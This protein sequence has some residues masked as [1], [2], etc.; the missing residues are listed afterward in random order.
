MSADLPHQFPDLLRDQRLMG[1]LKPQP[2][3]LRALD[4]LFVLVGRRGVAQAD[5]VSQVDLVLQHLGDGGVA[6]VVG[7]CG[8]QAG[9]GHAVL[10]E[11][12]VD[13]IEDLLLLQLPGDLAGSPPGG[14]QLEDPPHHLRCLRVRD[15]L[16]GI[17]PRLLVSISGSGGDPLPALGLGLLHRPD[18]PAGVLGVKLVSSLRIKHDKLTGRYAR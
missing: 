15:D 5:G 9:Q 10:L 11:V 3:R 13:R 6:P 4:L 7:A 14:A 16:P 2:L 17:V 1:V 12:V 18:F 8:V